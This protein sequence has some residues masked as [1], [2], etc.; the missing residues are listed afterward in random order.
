MDS[1]PSAESMMNRPCFVSVFDL[2][3][4]CA[5]GLLA[6]LSI[7]ALGSIAASSA[8]LRTFSRSIPENAHPT[9]PRQIHLRAKSDMNPC[10][11]LKLGGLVF[12]G[13]GGSGVWSSGEL[14]ESPPDFLRL[15]GRLDTARR[16]RVAVPVSLP[17][18][19]PRYS[20]ASPESPSSGP[21]SG[22]VGASTAGLSA[23]ISV[24]RS[25]S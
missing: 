11:S 2:L 19:R 15:A 20:P 14:S 25:A 22:F 24:N 4:I 3:A 5:S 10:H 6:V 1:S 18:C 9:Y 12:G 21:G 8:A 7:S 13:G 16:V 17:L 23:R